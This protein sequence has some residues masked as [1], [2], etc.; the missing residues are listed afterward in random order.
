MHDPLQRSN[1]TP[2]SQTEV[3]EPNCCLKMPEKENEKEK[4]AEVIRQ[5]NDNRLDLFEI[6]QPDEVSPRM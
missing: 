1:S 2:A 5:W 4:L 3:S 6:S